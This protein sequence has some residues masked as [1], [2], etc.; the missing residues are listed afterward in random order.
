M[1]LLRGYNIEKIK[2]II[3]TIDCSVASASSGFVFVNS[4]GIHL[5]NLDFESCGETI[6]LYGDK[7]MHSAAAL[8]FQH[9]SN[10]QLHSIT[11]K[12]TRGFGLHTSNVFGSISISE[13]AFLQSKGKK[14]GIAIGNAR[15]W[16]GVECGEQCSSSGVTHVNITSSQ[17]LDGQGNVNGLEVIIGCPSVYVVIE[18]STIRNNRGE[19]GGNLAL[20]V[21]DLGMPLNET[22]IKVSNSHI[23]EGRAKKGGGLR[24]WSRTDQK[25]ASICTDTN[26]HRILEVYN[27]TF[28]S[29]FASRTGG[30][31]Y[32][33]HY[34]S[35]G[36]DC[37][38]KKITFTLCKFEHN[39]GN[40]AAMEITK[41]LILADHA[42]PLLN[43]SFENCTFFKKFNF[44]SYCKWSSHE[45][46]H[47]LHQNGKLHH[48][49]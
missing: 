7:H 32:M 15:F 48:N 30:A 4:S 28:R 25:D 19:N 5:K 42:S 16:F 41:H 45:F 12:N 1:A 43:V 9:G 14:T 39:F 33:I 18:N 13:S 24:F 44:R 35:G 3:S 26:I 38:V 11:V 8:S 27:T 37:I 10:I 2:W 29:N 31:L 46:Y 22:I 34:Q 36:F 20:S 47:D 6:P 23:E 17:F 49:W 21:T 40:G